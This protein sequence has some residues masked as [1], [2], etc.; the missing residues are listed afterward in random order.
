MYGT[1]TLIEKIGVVETGNLIHTATRT[2]RTSMRFFT[3]A[4]LSSAR[5]LRQPD[6]L[7]WGDLHGEGRRG[8]SS[9]FFKVSTRMRALIQQKVDLGLAAQPAPI[10][11]NL[12]RGIIVVLQFRAEPFDGRWVTGHASQIHIHI[13]FASNSPLI[14]LGATATVQ[15]PLRS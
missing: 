1:S 9:I 10:V 7:E 12:A 6:P 2:A 14:I 3:E 13:Q 15:Q 5:A 8:C 11:S 4:P